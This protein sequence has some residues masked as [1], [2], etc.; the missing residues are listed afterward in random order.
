LRRGRV[1]KIKI[2]KKLLNLCIMLIYFF[3]FIYCFE[4]KNKKP[5][6]NQIKKTMKKKNFLPLLAVV[7]MMAT[8]CQENE[9]PTAAVPEATDCTDCLQELYKS[10]AG[11]LA[12][13]ATGTYNG[14]QINYKKI[15]GLNVREGDILIAPSQL[16]DNNNKGTIKSNVWPSRTIPYRFPSSTPKGARDKFLAA[17]RHWNEKLGFR[18]VKRT[19]QPNFINV[20]QDNG[21]YSFVGRIG[22]SQDL[23]IGSD[24][25]IGNAIHEIGH[26]VGLEHEQTRKDRDRFVTVNFRNIQNDAINNFEICKNCSS[27]GTLDFGSIMMYGPNFFSKNGRPTIVKKDGSLYSVQRKGLSRNDIGIVNSLYK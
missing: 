5:I 13:N 9:S 11:A 8:A 27:N 20:I 21:C 2:L 16:A 10:S 18:F 14:R 26:A 23:S 12:V 19:T 24:C 15:D 25:S 6:K 7:A 22:G 4:K 17:A 3:S 1:K